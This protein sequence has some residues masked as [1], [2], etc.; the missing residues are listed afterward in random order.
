MNLRGIPRAAVG[1]YVKVLRWP[2]DRVV[3]H[4]VATLTDLGVSDEDIGAVGAA[5]TEHRDDIV[6]VSDPA[7]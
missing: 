4:L 3:G 6:T 5:L 7:A 1:G 2:V